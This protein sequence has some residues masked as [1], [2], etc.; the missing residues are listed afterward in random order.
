[1][2]NIHKKKTY[3]KTLPKL[4]KKTKKYRIISA[5]QVKKQIY[6]YSNNGFGNKIFSLI[7]AIYLYNYYDGQC[8]I[9][10]ISTKSQHENPSDLDIIDIFPQSAY[11]IK[12]VFVSENNFKRALQKLEM[13]QL[14]FF[15]SIYKFYSLNRLPKKYYVGTIYNL[16]YKMYNTFNKQ[17]KSIFKINPNLIQNKTIL[18]LAKTDYSVIHIRYGDK[19][20]LMNKYLDTPKFDYF[21]IYTPQYYIDMI[22]MLLKKNPNKK[23]IILSDSFD[24]INEFIINKVPDFKNNP[25]IVLM[26]AHWLDSFYLFYN[27]SNIVMSCST[28]SMAGAYFNTKPYANVYLNLYHED[29]T[30]KIIPEE[31]SIS[32]KWTITHNREYILNYNVD[33]MREI[34]NYCIVHNLKCGTSIY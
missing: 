27:A 7:I 15:N 32:P 11:K 23:I 4:S 10:Y 17:D 12:Y 1:M 3:K 26:D 24:I 28:F 31:Y 19:I 9:N 2:K 34:L 33:L 16:V 8:D 30:K 25:N 20:H 18:G 6:V 5:T 21:L 22:N 13:K 29:M 14:Y